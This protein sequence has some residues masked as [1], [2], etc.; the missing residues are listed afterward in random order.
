MRVN[1]GVLFG[2]LLF[3]L[4]VLIWTARKGLKKTNIS[5]GN[6]PDK[7]VVSQAGRKRTRKSESHDVSTKLEV[8]LRFFS[9]DEVHSMYKAAITFGPQAK[10]IDQCRLEGK[11]NLK[12]EDMAVETALSVWAMYLVY[13]FTS[14]LRKMQQDVQKAYDGQ[15]LF[16]F[17]IVAFEAVVFI[18][19]SV[20]REYSEGKGSVDEYSMD[21]FE[22]LK[23]SF[24]TSASIMID[25]SGFNL[26]EDFL[27]TRLAA[28][29]LSEKFKSLSRDKK[30]CALL[31]SSVNKGKVGGI[32]VHEGIPHDLA[33]Q[34]AAESYIPIFKSS[35]LD[36]FKEK[37]KE[38]YVAHRRGML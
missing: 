34:V 6:R 20:I 17:D 3:C 26:S 10:T 18:Y 15:S 16:P 38:M 24:H 19:D 30:F 22:C 29:S 23:N 5:N 28:Y 36:N 32:R 25:N 31:I 8:F 1:D 7:R 33:F 35:L 2:F 4:V 14:G 13:S 37:A 9:L 12:P 27:I 21:Y 11:V